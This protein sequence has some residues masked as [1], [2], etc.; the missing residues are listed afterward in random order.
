MSSN[1]E[2]EANDAQDIE[3]GLR[4]ACRRVSYE[5]RGS[6]SLTPRQFMEREIYMSW[7][8][9]LFDTVLEP[10]QSMVYFQSTFTRLRLFVHHHS[11]R[12]DV[13][14]AVEEAIG[15]MTRVQSTVDELQVMVN[16]LMA[17]AEIAY[18]HVED[19]TIFIRKRNRFTP[20]QNSK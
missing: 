15:M 6:S 1:P 19:L 10:L 4:D 8:Y 18:L 17:L 20:I 14:R 3:Y 13:G 7:I 9:Y 11:G 16:C 5:H 12:I 2:H